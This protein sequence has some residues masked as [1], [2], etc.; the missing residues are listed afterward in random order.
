MY[1]SVTSSTAQGGGGSFKNR[2][3]L[4]ETG[5]CAWTTYGPHSKWVPVDQFSTVCVLCSAVDSVTSYT[6]TT[7]L[8][9][10]QEGRSIGVVA[11]VGVGVGVVVVVVLRAVA[12]AV[13]GAAIVAVVA[14]VAVVAAVALVA[15]VAV[16]EEVAVV[17]SCSCSCSVVE[18]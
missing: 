15:V 13:A 12:V 1:I 7:S 3:P 4:G 2:K 18:L 11:G 5:R 9:L 8:V 14:V 10:G 6:G 17:R 16:E